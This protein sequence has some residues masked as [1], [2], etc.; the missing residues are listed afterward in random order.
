MQDFR[1]IITDIISVMRNVEQFLIF[2][3]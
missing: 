1:I 2:F 3:I